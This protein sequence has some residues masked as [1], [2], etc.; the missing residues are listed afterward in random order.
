MLKSGITEIKFAY[1]YFFAFFSLHKQYGLCVL[2]F[3]VIVS[4][5]K[6]NVGSVLKVSNFIT[7]KGIVVQWKI[8]DIDLSRVNV[9]SLHAKK[10]NS[11]KYIVH[12][13]SN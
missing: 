13:W 5:S 10:I 12:S 3:Q 9:I 8:P 1:E 7:F 4:L 2:T 6:L 11:G